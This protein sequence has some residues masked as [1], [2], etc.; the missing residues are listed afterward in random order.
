[1][2]YTEEQ[3]IQLK[4]KRIGGFTKYNRPLKPITIKDGFYI[5]ESKLNN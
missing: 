3:K 5:I 2:K 1:M 4:N